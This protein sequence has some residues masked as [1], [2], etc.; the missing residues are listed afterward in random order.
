MLSRKWIGRYL[1]VRAVGASAALMATG[2]LLAY[3]VGYFF[4]LGASNS[5]PAKNGP[6]PFDAAPAPIQPCDQKEPVPTHIVGRLAPGYTLANLTN[7]GFQAVK[8]IEGT[9]DNLILVKG[10]DRG[11]KA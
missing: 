1:T 2:V 6:N 10:D 7:A 11:F 4:G 9:E 3:A 8:A 5:A